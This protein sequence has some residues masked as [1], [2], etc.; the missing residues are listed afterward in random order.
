MNNYLTNLTAF[1]NRYYKASTG[2]QASVW[3]QNTLKS[4]A[5]SRSDITVTAFNHSWV[6]TSTIAKF[7]GTATTAPTTILGAHMDSINLSS[8]LNGRAPGADDDG[9]GVVN[10]IEIFKTLVKTGYK[11]ASP[12]EFHFYS[13]EEAGLLGSQAIAQSYSTKGASVKAMLELDMT[14]YFKPGTKEAITFM[15]DNTDGM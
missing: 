3:I 15:T 11:P 2:L 14:G 9:T 6:Q 5:G 10:L 13:G 12:L 4:I 8:P 1:N 7:A